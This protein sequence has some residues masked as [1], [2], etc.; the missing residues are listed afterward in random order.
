[1][2]TRDL[3]TE[4]F[5]D[6]GIIAAGEV[7]S[8]TDAANGLK[9]LTRL[10]DNWNAERRA[11]YATRLTSYTIVPSTQP[12]TIGP[13][14][15]T[16]TATQRP[17]SIDGANLVLNDVTPSIRMP[18]NIR[19]DDWY[20]ALT[21]PGLTSTVPTDLYYSAEWPLGQIYLWPVPTVAYGLE[22][23]MRIV[24]ADLALDDDVS[25]PPG[26]LDAVTLTLGEMLAPSYGLA[27][28]PSK[29]AAA[30][31]RIMSNNDDTPLLVT[32]DSGMPS[33][34][35]G[36]VIPTYYYRTGQDR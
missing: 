25:L 21:V 10:L 32:Q 3:L 19:D 7:L 14:G 31:G 11:V 8:A 30:R 16:F 2:T 29:A 13:T 34:R 4:C 17:V 36:S 26:Y 5:E 12:S 9:K 18:I 28:D 15:A 24:L 35:S 22:L 27:V 20:R 23:Q 1:M 33:N 6:L